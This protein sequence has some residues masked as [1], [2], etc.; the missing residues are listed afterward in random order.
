M[1]GWSS[2]FPNI[3]FN[4]LNQCLIH[5]HHKSQEKFMFLQFNH[6]IFIV[7]IY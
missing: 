7:I 5:N 3:T 1:D 6:P 2:T 4:I